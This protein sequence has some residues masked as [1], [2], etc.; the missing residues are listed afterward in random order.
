MWNHVKNLNSY[1]SITTVL[2]ATKLGRMVTNLLGFLPMLLD[3]FSHVV[4]WRTKTLY[5]HYHNAYGHKTR[6]DGDSPSAASTHK[7]TWPYNEVVL[8]DRVVN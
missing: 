7:V 2:M 5:L 8:G 6:Q 3:L 1:I 4:T